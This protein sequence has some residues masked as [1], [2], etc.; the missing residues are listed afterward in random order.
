[1]VKLAKSCKFTLIEKFSNTM[2]K[3]DTIRKEFLI[4]TELKEIVKMT[5]FNSMYLYRDLDN[6]Y[7]QNVTST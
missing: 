5:H 1:M 3:M 4:Q 7:G 2:P 6:A